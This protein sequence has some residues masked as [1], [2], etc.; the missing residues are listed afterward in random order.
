MVDSLLQSAQC[1]VQAFAAGFGEFQDLRRRSWR[2]FGKLTARDNIKFVGLSRV[3][4]VT[5]H[6]D[7]RVEYPFVVLTPEIEAEMAGLVHGC[8]TL[9]LT[10][11]PRGGGTGYTGGA[12]PFSFKS[13]TINTENRAGQ[14]EFM[15]HG[16]AAGELA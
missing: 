11:I 8:M 12:C 13:A 14:S 3:S 9:G 6:T 7:W 1:A 5:D 16:G 10:V 15:A 4:H 2:Q